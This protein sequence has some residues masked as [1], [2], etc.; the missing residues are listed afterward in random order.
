MVAVVC[1]S[2]SL[3]GIPNFMD[4]LSTGIVGLFWY[5]S[6]ICVFRES[7]CVALEDLRVAL[8]TALLLSVHW[9]YVFSRR[10]QMSVL[11]HWVGWKVLFGV[12][13]CIY[14]DMAALQCRLRWLH[15][16]CDH[17]MN[18]SL[19]Y[20]KKIAWSMGSLLEG[21]GNGHCGSGSPSCHDLMPYSRAS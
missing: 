20:T 17:P 21:K 12:L 18:D 9:L 19:V 15:S 5:A 4:L 3:R 16:V 6:F 10:V 2:C 7:L 11:V 14:V 8:R 1:S 13:Y